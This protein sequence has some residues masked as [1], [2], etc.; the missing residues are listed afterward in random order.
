MTQTTPQTKS[1]KG[2]IVAVSIAIPIVVAVLYLLPAPDNISPELR[3]FLNNLPGLNALINGTTLMVLIGALLAIKNKKVILHRR[4]MTLALVLSALF[5]VSYVAYHLTS[6]STSYGGEGFMKGLYLF[7]LLT[8][9][10]LS[11]VI[12]P[13]VQ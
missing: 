8:H 3:S 10:L 5:L 7:I 11:A 12:V 13:L 6:P 9:I 1:Y 2:L 4:L